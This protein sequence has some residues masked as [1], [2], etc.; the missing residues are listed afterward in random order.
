MHDVDAAR[1]GVEHLLQEGALRLCLGVCCVL[2]LFQASPLGDVAVDLQDGGGISLFVMYQHL[3]TLDD[4]RTTI[5][6][7]VHQFTLPATR[8]LKLGFHCCLADRE[9][10]LEQNVGYPSQR[11]VRGPAVELLRALIP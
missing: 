9:T 4:D 5:A 6:S 1:H 8:T 10:R 2:C 3:T 7:C 11:L